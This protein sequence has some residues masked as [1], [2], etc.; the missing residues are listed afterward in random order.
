MLH[1]NT[2]CTPFFPSP[3][4]QQISQ[5]GTKCHP[6]DLRHP[7]GELWDSPDG[8]ARPP[9]ERHPFLPPPLLLLLLG[10]DGDRCLQH[11]HRPDGPRRPG[12]LGLGPEDQLRVEQP[13]PEAG[14][15]RA[16]RGGHV[17]L[18]GGEV[19]GGGQRGGLLDGPAGSGG[20]I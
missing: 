6:D 7:H 8:P 5:P 11:H 3:P 20:V 9:A 17:G 2:P 1:T 4:P 13:H 16:V 18:R 10:P 14:S 15:V 19:C 12:G